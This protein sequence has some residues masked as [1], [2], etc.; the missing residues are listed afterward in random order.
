MV[1]Y[2]ALFIF[3]SLFVYALVTL[4]TAKRSHLQN[5][6]QT[7][8]AT[9]VAA[10]SQTLNDEEEN[11]SFYE[12]M[13]APFWD[14]AKQSY[15]KKL[16]NDVTSKLEM[17]LLQAGLSTSPVGF[18]L[19]QLLLCVVF[20][21]IGVG[22]GLLSGQNPGIAI[23]IAV[24]GIAIASFLPNYYLKTKAGKRSQQAEKEIPDLLDLLTISLEAGLGFD[25]ALAQV[26]A[27]KHGVLSG[28]FKTAL[29][30][31]RLGKTRKEA[32]N[33][34][35]QRLLSEDLRSLIYSIIQADK[36]GIGMVSVL[37][38]QT[39]DMRER[40]KQRAE[41]AAMKA[42]I[43]MMFPLVIFIF[44]TLFIILLGPALLQFME[45]F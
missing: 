14:Q 42:P 30:E 21:A 25:A 32:L 28:E 34:M 31:M 6:I 22:Y 5:R 17:K 20:I 13:I 18:K 35:T 29:E 43:K 38:V 37:R 3:M 19:F 2:G 23:L 44:P 1:L 33:D 39:E 11:V 9:D 36:L 12:R 4:V 10:S 26:V 24:T 40:R 45:A 7:Y 27:K 16:G 41:E 15:K 8:F